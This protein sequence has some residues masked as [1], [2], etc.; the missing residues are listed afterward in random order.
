MTRFRLVLLLV[1]L[2]AP[3][4]ASPQT[5]TAWVPWPTSSALRSPAVPKPLQPNWISDPSD[6]VAKIRPTYWKEGTAVGGEVGRLALGSWSPPFAVS[7]RARRAA[8]ARHC[9]GG[10]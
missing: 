9:L 2:H 1:L 5:S 10:W 8:P 6:S 3:L 7:R 4:A